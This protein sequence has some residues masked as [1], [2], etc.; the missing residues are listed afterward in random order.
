LQ[1]HELYELFGFGSKS[2]KI[3][4]WYSSLLDP[5]NSLD[6]LACVVPSKARKFLQTEW[7]N[8]HKMEPNH[9][10]IDFYNHVLTK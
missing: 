8:N 1:V 10:Y 6:P 4:P 7:H 5:E 3:Q 2:P 9:V